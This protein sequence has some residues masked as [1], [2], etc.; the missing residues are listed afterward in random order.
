[1][2][3]MDFLWTLGNY[4][5]KDEGYHFIFNVTFWCSCFVLHDIYWRIVF[6]H[7]S[8]VMRPMICKHKFLVFFL[9][10]LSMCLCMFVSFSTRKS[11][12]N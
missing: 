3:P 2:L 9:F 11:V 6:N 7:L 5:P 4:F 12:G 8:F 10:L 1:M